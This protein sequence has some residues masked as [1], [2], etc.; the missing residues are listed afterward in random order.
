MVIFERIGNLF[1]SNKPHNDLR[2]IYLEISSL[3][4]IIHDSLRDLREM[5]VRLFNILNSF[6]KEENKITGNLEIEKTLFIEEG[7]IFM[8]KDLSK[9]SGER[10]I[11]VEEDIEK[12]KPTSF[13]ERDEL[14]RIIDYLE[15]IKNILP[16]KID[17]DGKTNKE[18]LKI[19]NSA[20]RSITLLSKEFYNLEILTEDLKRRITQNEISPLL[21]RVFNNAKELSPEA[22]IL[23]FPVNEKE[24]RII[25][26]ESRK[27][28]SCQDKNY[29]ILWR[30]WWR[31][32]QIP[33]YDKN[34][35]LKDSHINV[36]MRLFGRKKEIH[37]ILSLKC[38]QGFRI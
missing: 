25:E 16:V 31:E 17:L 5:Q 22:K 18:K 4:S 3:S 27:I 36:T 37:L 12:F 9:K 20:L 28:N 15:D 24:L 2:E 1:L 21:K 13:I 32:L 10:F 29:S 19:I 34:T 35:K 30:R 7:L 8:L 26:D 6:K 23:I 14:K 38:W 33:E 11:E